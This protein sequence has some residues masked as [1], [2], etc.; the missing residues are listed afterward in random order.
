[1]KQPINS[2][3][4]V[5]AV[6]LSVLGAGLLLSWFRVGS[7]PRVDI[8]AELPGI[9]P[10]TPIVVRLAEPGRG[11]SQ[12]TVELVQTDRRGLLEERRHEPRPFWAFWGPLVANDEI[13]VEVGSETM[14]E[15]KAGEATVRVTA[16]RATTW[17]RHPE[18]VVRE[19]TLPVRLTPPQ[20]RVSS[21]QIYLAQ[22]GSAVV[23]YQVGETAV[24]DGVRVARPVE[25]GPTEQPPAGGGQLERPPEGGRAEHWF[26]GY[27]LPGGAAEERFALFGAPHDLDDASKIRL[28]AVDELGNMREV[29]FLDRYLERPLQTDTIRLSDRFMTKVVPEIIA[30]SAEVEDRGDLLETYLAIN[31]DLR[32]KNTEALFE[33][34]AR[35]TAQFFWDQPFRQLPNTR[36]MASYADRRTYLYDGREVDSQD[37]LGFD[38]ASV[39]RAPVLAAN[40]GVVLMAEYFGI[41]GNAV[42]LDHGYGLM[43]LYAHMSNLEV[44]TGQQV[45]RGEV[46]GATGETGLAGG[47]HL[48]FSMLLHGLQVNP[49]EW[50]DP[51]WIENRFA[52]KLG[53][54]FALED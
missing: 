3:A 9:G 36:S 14:P 23:V 13:V 38:L 2:K 29:A 46:L 52:R 10:R 17:L 43:S 8:E 24:R 35:T 28:Q 49:L 6:L 4:R 47:D 18:P 48:H 32:R 15:L 7:P 30:R 33:L 31:R 45:D 1:M 39:R 40:R 51:S 25:G 42:V 53:A 34:A 26:P 16:E 50:W 20:V 22:G 41:Y 27:P 5:L 21:S 54:A 12:V 37:H 19:L 44:Q 11:L